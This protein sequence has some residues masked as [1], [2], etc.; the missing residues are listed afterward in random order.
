M[1]LSL[2]RGSSTQPV[3][4]NYE[5]AKEELC[6][7]AK[8]PAWPSFIEIGQDVHIANGGLRKL[9]NEGVRQAYEKAICA[10]RQVGDPLFNRTNTKDNT[11][12]SFIPLFW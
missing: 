10:S 12:P 11:P 5:I 9:V 7:S 1:R 3:D 4:Q 8:I 2:H 6:P